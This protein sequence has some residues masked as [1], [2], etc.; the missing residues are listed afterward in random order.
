VPSVGTATTLGVSL[1]R[2]PCPCFAQGLSLAFLLVTTSVSAAVQ[3]LV[4]TGL[5]GEPIFEQRFEGWARNLRDVS[6]QRFGVSKDDFRWLAS[7]D[8]SDA[9]GRA[10][11]ESIKESV[12]QF[13]ESGRPDAPLLL[14]LIG[15]GTVRGPD[16]SFNLRGPDLSPGTLSTLLDSFGSRPQV[17]VNAAS[18]SG[19]FVRQLSASGRVVVTATAS[20][21]EHHVT[22][23]G[24]HFIDAFGS[25][26]ADADKDNRVSMFEAFQYARIQVKGSFV[27]DHLLQTEHALLDDNGDGIGSLDPARDARDGSVARALYLESSAVP[28]NPRT[29]QAR[30]A[31]GLEAR[32]L[33]ADIEALKRRRAS[34]HTARYHNELEAILVKLA[35]N[36]RAWRTGVG[37]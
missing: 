10:T 8:A 25:D 11:L 6:T 29:A 24:G 22:R 12:A 28:D 19:P 13:A 37:Q 26:A 7:T 32:R 23:F 9:N 33:L 14:V 27:A 5:G 30:L 3:V 17:V 1:V 35:L 15:H 2:A 4:V 20:A 18:A 34:L 31:L 21:A 36:R 16:V